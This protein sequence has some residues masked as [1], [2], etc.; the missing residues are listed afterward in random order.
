MKDE[1]ELRRRIN[2]IQRRRINENLKYIRSGQAARDKER[3]SAERKAARKQRK[4]DERQVLRLR[5]RIAT[6]ECERDELQRYLDELLESPEPAYSIDDVDAAIEGCV[7]EL[8]DLRDELR[9][10]E[11]K[12]NA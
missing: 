1:A 11:E 9:V 7:N 2:E 6:V 10:L 4:R 3:L 8:G 12:L 5:K